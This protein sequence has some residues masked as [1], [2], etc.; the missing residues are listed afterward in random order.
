[1]HP[2]KPKIVWDKDKKLQMFA[3]QTDMV[4]QEH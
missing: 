1:M 4:K 2:V 3:K